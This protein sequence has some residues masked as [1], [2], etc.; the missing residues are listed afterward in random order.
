MERLAAGLSVPVSQARALRSQFLRSF[1]KLEHFQETIRRQ[2][3]QHGSVVT[4]GGRRRR[5]PHITSSNGSERAKAERQAVNS[6]IQV[7]IDGD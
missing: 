1:P 3:R 2:A 5:L 6:V 7:P 4:L